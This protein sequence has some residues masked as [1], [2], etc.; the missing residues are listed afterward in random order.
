MQIEAIVHRVTRHFLALSHLPWSS[1]VFLDM[2][3]IDK[4]PVVSAAFSSCNAVDSSI[5]SCVNV[6]SSWKTLRRLRR[7][8][9]LS[10]IKNQDVLINTLRARER[11]TYE[12]LETLV[13]FNEF[14]IA[15]RKILFI[16]RRRT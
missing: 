1:D 2:T 13:L 8:A 3:D 9:R 4:S 11:L 10:N 6:S 12:L 16:W 15:N 14:S 7:S 5:N